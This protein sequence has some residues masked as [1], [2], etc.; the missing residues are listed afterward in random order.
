[1]TKFFIKEN[2]NIYSKKYSNLSAYFINKPTFEDIESLLRNAEI[3]I[4]CHCAVTH[5]ANS[6]NL[7]IIDIIEESKKEWYSRFTLYIKE[8]KQIYRSKFSIIKNQLLSKIV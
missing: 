2:D 8:Y 6:F 7:K 1:M 5:A 4:S 3:F